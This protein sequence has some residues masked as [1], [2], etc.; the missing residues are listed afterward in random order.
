MS[1]A[2]IFT[3][4]YYARLA[5]Q[6]EA[7]WWSLGMRAIAAGL[8]D[9][10]AAPQRNWRVLDAGCG[11]GLTMQWLAR[12][13]EVEPVGLDLAR[14]GLQF[15]A[16]RGSRRLVEGS[17][18]W[19][20]FPAEAFE[21]VVSTDVIQH[22]PRPSGDRQAF[23]EMGR[24]LRT[25]GLLLL[26][27]N[28]RCGYPETNASDYH[29]YT[30]AEVR[31]LATDAG[32]TVHTASY[33]NCLPGLVASARMRLAGSQVANDPGLRARTRPPD[34]NLVTRAFYRSLLAE[35]AYLSPGGRS[36]PFGHSILLLAQKR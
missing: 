25:G 22:L 1:E 18:T 17:T 12:Y 27:T 9:R 31:M 32:L 4:E 34:T 5:H 33:V 10:F 30:L 28:S 26:R 36:L 29:R 11:T 2:H 35:G 19:L 20:P 3:D 8:V 24:V 6:E 15:C 16:R 13:T 21:L 7:H 14:A 23:A